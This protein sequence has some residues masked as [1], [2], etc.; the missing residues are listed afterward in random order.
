MKKVYGISF[1]LSSFERGL[2]FDS[3]ER[4]YTPK[5]WGIRF[6]IVAGKMMWPMEKFWIKNQ[7]PWNGGEIWFVIRL[8]FLIAP[9]LSVSLG[10][11]GFYIGCKTF[12]CKPRHLDLSNYGKWLRPEECGTDEE[13]AEYLQPSMTWRITRWK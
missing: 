7:N 2:W 6:N 8:P 11:I 5:G 13:P 3:D 1:S 9:F 12:L 10:P 4:L